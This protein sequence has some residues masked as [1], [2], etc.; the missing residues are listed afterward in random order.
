MVKKTAST[1]ESDFAHSIEKQVTNFIVGEGTKSAA[2][3]AGQATQTAASA[4]GIASRAAAEQA[5]HDQSLLLNLET[6][7]KTVTNNAVAAASAAFQFFASMGPLGV[8]LGAAAAAATFTAVEAFGALASA[9]GGYDIGSENPLTQLH[10]KEMV[11]P[12]S[13]AEP[14]RGM[15]ATNGGG[16]G[17]LGPGRV[18]APTTPPS[19]ASTAAPSAA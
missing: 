2:T 18:A 5:G 19:T 11:L 1:A 16:G 10:A 9:S 15:I 14:L 7:L 3:Q 6:T 4:T 12:A 8:P 17:A 13:I